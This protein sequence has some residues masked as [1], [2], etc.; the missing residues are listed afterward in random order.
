M[1]RS[2]PTG[3]QDAFFQQ[4]G[5]LF[6]GAIYAHDPLR[7]LYLQGLI[8][9]VTSVSQAFTVAVTY[10]SDGNFGF[11]IDG[12]FIPAAAS[13][14]S[15]TSA[16]ALNTAIQ[17][18]IATFGTALIAS[19]SVL[20]NVVT[21]V[22][23]DD[24]SH[25]LGELETGTT[26][27]VVDETVAA[28]SYAKLV[29]GLGVCLDTVTGFD[30]SAPNLRAIRGPTGG[31][32]VLLGVLGYEMRQSSEFQRL[33]LG[34]DAAFLPPL[35]PYRVVAKGSIVVPWVGTLPTGPSSAVYWINDPATLSQRGKFRS[36]ANGGEADLVSGFVEGIIPEANLVK[37][38]FDL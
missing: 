24:A 12:L 11:S 31:S 10:G 4:P 27:L 28:A 36:D 18:Y 9:P 21:V 23:A 35:N 1:A 13:V 6:Q 25:T 29:Y 8:R 7:D 32:D 16:A 3:L 26:T 34:Y 15:D 19:S 14:D 37:V 38:K 5:P 30:L 33:A 22:L 17:D 20:A 2:F